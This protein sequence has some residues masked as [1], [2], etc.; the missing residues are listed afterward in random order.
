MPDREKVIK[1]LEQFKADMKPFFGNHADWER[2]DAG[3]DLLKE[4]PE[5]VRCGQCA[6]WKPPHIRL[7]DG[8]QRIYREGE[9]ERDPFGIGVSSDVGMNVGGMCWRE[10]NRGYGR[11]MRVF[12]KEDDYCSRGQKRPEGVTAE[13]YW[14]LS[15]EPAELRDDFDD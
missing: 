3:L 10:Q 5:I 9:K 4:Q 15:E 13:Q 7:N 6:H 12:R 1:G 8:K 11:D 2:F 14:G